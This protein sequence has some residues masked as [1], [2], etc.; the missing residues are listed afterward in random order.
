MTESKATS[1]SSDEESP[2]TTSSFSPIRFV[3]KW[4]VIPYVIGWTLSEYLPSELTNMAVLALFPK[5]G[6]NVSRFEVRRMEETVEKGVNELK[7]EA[8]CHVGFCMPS[9]TSCTGTVE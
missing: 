8:E 1:K 7:S 3:L 6:Q 5:A 2:A 4:I 9:H